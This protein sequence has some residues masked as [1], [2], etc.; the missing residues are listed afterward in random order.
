M[1]NKIDKVASAIKAYV[2]LLVLLVG[3]QTARD[4]VQ[5]IVEAMDVS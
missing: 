1:E 4:M 3:Y 2:R 5:A